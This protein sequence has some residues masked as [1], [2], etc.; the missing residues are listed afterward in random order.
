MEINKNAAD[1][2]ANLREGNSQRRQLQEKA[3]PR[4][5]YTKRR[6]FQEKAMSRECNAK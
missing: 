6:E 5:G 3:T 1:M 2:K 4:E